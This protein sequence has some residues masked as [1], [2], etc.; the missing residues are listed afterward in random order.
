[1]SKSNPT[2]PNQ[3]QPNPTTSNHIQPNPP[4]QTQPNPT[5]PY[6]VQINQRQV[7]NFRLHLSK[8]RRWTWCA[9]SGASWT[10]TRS[11]GR[12][13]FR[14]RRVF[15]L[16]CP[17]FFD[18]FEKGASRKT[19]APF[20]GVPKNRHTQ[21]DEVG[22]CVCVCVFRGGVGELVARHAKFRVSLQ[23]ATCSCR[24]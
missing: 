21:L 18:G 2:K 12:A 19:V 5:K 16:G 20:S 7:S 11:R 8:S 24:C 6:H 3:T 9:A 22:V 13:F 4:R 17:G 10:W 23:L 1:M 15:L 14:G